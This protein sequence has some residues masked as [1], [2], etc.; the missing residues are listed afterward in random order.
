MTDGDEDVLIYAFA[1]KELIDGVQALYTPTC[2][3]NKYEKDFENCTPEFEDLWD[4]LKAGI[5][6]ASLDMLIPTEINPYLNNDLERIKDR[7]F[8]TTTDEV[9]RWAI[10][11]TLLSRG[12]AVYC[13]LTTGEKGIIQIA[14]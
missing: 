8:A 13:N 11:A 5:D 9:V 3:Y 14:D 10:I 12:V 7:L 1:K 4:E 6:G 2:C